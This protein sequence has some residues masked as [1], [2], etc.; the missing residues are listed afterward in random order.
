MF[1]YNELILLYSRLV[2][3]SKNRLNLQKNYL[4]KKKKMVI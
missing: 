4:K 2:E 1:M 3:N